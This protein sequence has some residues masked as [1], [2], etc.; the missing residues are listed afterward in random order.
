MDK[1]TFITKYASLFQIM[2]NQIGYLHWKTAIII[3]YKFYEKNPKQ[4][5][6]NIWFPNV[7]NMGIG[8]ANHGNNTKNCKP[9]LSIFVNYINFTKQLNN[10]LNTTT[11][12]SLIQSKNNEQKQ[13]ELLKNIGI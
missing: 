9:V 8:D 6:K 1:K 11:Q 7:Q 3:S 10:K 13:L 5:K 12:N 4:I 2:C